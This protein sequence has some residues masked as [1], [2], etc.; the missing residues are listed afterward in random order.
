MNN[1]FQGC[2]NN[3]ASFN[4]SGAETGLNWD[5]KGPKPLLAGT[6]IILFKNIAKQ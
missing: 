5:G 1:C 3:M 6:L 4:V 2:G